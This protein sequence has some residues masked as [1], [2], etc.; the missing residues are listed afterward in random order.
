MRSKKAAG[1]GVCLDGC[2]A[3]MGGVTRVSNRYETSKHS[4]V[5]ARLKDLRGWQFLAMRR[6]AFVG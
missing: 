4:R 2:F 1:T 5:T 6:A 3:M